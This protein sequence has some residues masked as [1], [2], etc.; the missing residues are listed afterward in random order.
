MTGRSA[1]PRIVL[2]FLLAAAIAWAL[3]NRDSLDAAAIENWV[4]GLDFWAPAAFVSLWGLWALLFLPGAILGLAGGALFGPV[5]GTL[6]NLAG[7]TLGA[8]L[9]FLAARFVASDWV[10]RKAGGR[11]KQLLE[12]VDSEGWRFVAFVRLVPLFPFNMLNYALGLTRIR[13]LAYLI[14][15]LVCMLPGTIAYTYLGYAGREATAGGEGLIQKGLLALGLLAAVAFLPRLV[16]RLRKPSL[17]WIEADVLKRRLDDDEDL[18]VIDVREPD[19]FIG[20]L[21]HIPGS[22]NIPLGSLPEQIDHIRTLS[23]APIILVCRTDKRSAGAARLL[24]DAG[25]RN[26]P[27]LRG[28]VEGWSARGFDVLPRPE[29][30]IS[31]GPTEQ[32]P[33]KS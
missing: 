33:R 23:P 13:F 14:T 9:A 27:V 8:G 3:F 25:I 6:W 15:T 10:A 21:G 22:R 19:E 30:G 16:R 7:A 2:G 4:D 26:V 18:A 24:H 32:S 17:D 20:P 5:W 11:L 1:L 12:G 29:G 31:N 28:G